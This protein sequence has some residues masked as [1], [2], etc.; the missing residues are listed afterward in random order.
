MIGV[1]KIVA[2]HRLQ[3]SRSGNQPGCV[4]L[5]RV[6]ARRQRR[7]GFEQSRADVARSHGRRAEDLP[8]EACI[9]AHAFDFGGFE[10]VLQPFDRRRA[11]GCP[12]DQ[13]R[14]HRVVVDRD[15][16]TLLHAR[17]DAHVLR[18][19]GK[20]QARQASRRRQEAALRIFG[21]QPRLDRMAAAR[22]CRL[23]ERQPFARGDTQLPFDEV[24]P[25]DHFG[26][27]MLDLQA[28]VH[29]EE[30][31]LGAVEQELDRAGAAIT[32]RLCRRHRRCAHRRAR[33]VGQAR[34]RGFLD[35]FLV[36]ALQRAVAL[37]QVHGVA[38]RVGEDLD[39][40][41]PA[42]L[43]EAFEQHSI[44]AE[45]LRGFAARTGERFGEL[46][47]RRARCACPCRRRPPSA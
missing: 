14:N 19:G 44:V 40:D 12:D 1:P 28:R 17:I 30:I 6:D 5:V 20:A 8:E 29:L 27:R 23:L 35:D 34:G 37:V 16:V 10:R 31:E 13:L 25:G 11:I 18:G 24:E 36:A 21:V 22:D 9:G 15:F 32:D 4:D 38:V 2:R 33:R 3:A 41:V 43:D 26:D 42:L 47:L 39:L 46:G 7:I 45:G